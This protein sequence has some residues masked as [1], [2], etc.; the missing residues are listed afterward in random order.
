[1]KKYHSRETNKRKLV[2]LVYYY[3]RHLVTAYGLPESNRK[4]VRD[5]VFAKTMSTVLDKY[6]INVAVNTCVP[7][8]I[9]TLEE[10]LFPAELSV[11]LTAEVGDEEYVILT[12][13]D[14]YTNMGDVPHYL[15]G[16]EGVKPSMALEEGS[17]IPVTTHK[18]N[19]THTLTTIDF[20]ES[21]DE[22][23]VSRDFALKGHN[24]K[25]EW[26]YLVISSEYLVG[27]LKKHPLPYKG[28]MK[29]SKATENKKEQV[30]KRLKYIEER[31]S[32]ELRTELVSY[33]SFELQ[34]D[35]RYHDKPVLRYKETFTLSDL[36]Q[37][38]GGNYIL[39]I[40]KFIGGQVE[41]KEDMQDRLYDIYMPYARSFVNEIELTIPEGYTVEGV[42]ALNGEVK[43]KTGMFKSTA[44]VEDNK[45]IIEA[46]KVYKH[47]YEPKENWSQMIDFLEA[48]YQ[49]SQ[50]KVVLKKK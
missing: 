18:D 29:E 15:E 45:L 25:S 43:N 41:I 32:R 13:F 19:Q 20:N 50:Q 48:A 17:N 12:N 2:S 1:M 23:K 49:F 26:D 35:G 33:D 38:A 9:G 22:L 5:L 24:R 42:E 3:F 37:K 47:N 40:G 30:E 28:S 6:D 11:F 39:E 4:E 8:T 44:K 46:Q 21:M 10:V 7:R 31:T 16:A 36:L 14:E 34:A 27:D